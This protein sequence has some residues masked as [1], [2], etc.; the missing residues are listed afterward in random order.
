MTLVK[1]INLAVRFALELCA[2]AAT[3]YWGATADRRR[4]GRILLAVAAP[5][6][7]GVVWV[8]VVA[9]GATIQTTP[10]VRLLV[11][12]AVFGAAGAALVRRRRLVLAVVLGVG[13]MVNRALMA[14]W[15]Q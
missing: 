7:V 11:E 3:A 14:A 8:L 12:L 9:P 13:Y 6:A 1:S 15:D 2:L 4:G 5:L 10:W